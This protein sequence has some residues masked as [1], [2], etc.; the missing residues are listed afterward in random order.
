MVA[1]VV[2]EDAIGVIWGLDGSEIW[3]GQSGEG[4]V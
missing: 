4:M 3:G 1:S 2:I